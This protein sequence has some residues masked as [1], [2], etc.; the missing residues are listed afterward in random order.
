MVKENYLTEENFN[1]KIKKWERKL[2]EYNDRWKPFTLDDSALVV[3]DMQ[4][5]F[6]S[7]SSHAFVVSSKFITGNIIKLIDQFRDQ[8]KLIV[9]TRFA[10]K[11]DE[12]DPIENWWNNTVKDGSFNSKINLIVLPDKN[13]FVIR[14]RT[15]DSFYNT[16]LEKLLREKKIKNLIITGVLTNLCCETTARSAF[17]RNF[18]VYFVIDATAAYN[19]EMHLSSLRNISYGFATPVSTKEI[20]NDL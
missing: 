2:S 9:F 6:L 1:H 4:N 11:P 17:N 10:V 7:E 19:E 18:N 5:Y 14:K 12:N 13:E 8:G 3:I 15:Y 20:L 16:S